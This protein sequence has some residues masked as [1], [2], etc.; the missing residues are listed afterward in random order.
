VSPRAP[1]RPTNAQILTYAVRVI[2]TT[3]G[4]GSMK[5]P[6]AKITLAADKLIELGGPDEWA[7]LME[8]LGYERPMRRK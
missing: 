3:N 5:V 1:R 6:L 7:G 2:E 8:A 4:S